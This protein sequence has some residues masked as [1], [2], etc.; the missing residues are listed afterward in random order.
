M[1]GPGQPSS[2]RNR[3]YQ[4]CLCVRK[5]SM[6]RT[7]SAEAVGRMTRHAST[8]WSERISSKPLSPCFATVSIL[9]P[10]ISST[11]W[12][13]TGNAQ[14]SVVRTTGSADVYQAVPAQPGRFTAHRL[15]SSEKI[16]GVRHCH[17]RGVVPRTSACD[18][19]DKRPALAKQHL[20]E[21]VLT[22]SIFRSKIKMNH[23]RIALHFSGHSG[24][25]GT[26]PAG[27]DCMSILPQ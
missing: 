12:S 25:Q 5:E 6:V 14:T 20:R 23:W 18:G 27:S 19:H 13:T 2:Q 16:G 4:A 3:I 17:E 9:H 22:D 10:F 8:S 11:W 24:G 15:H 26:A 21:A 1:Q 7:C